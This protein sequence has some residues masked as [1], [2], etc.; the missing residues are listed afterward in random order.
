MAPAVTDRELDPGGFAS[1]DNLEV[2]GPRVILNHHLHYLPRY[3]RHF[4]VRAGKLG[5][6]VD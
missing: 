2:L 5:D 1:I 3:N 6:G 4:R